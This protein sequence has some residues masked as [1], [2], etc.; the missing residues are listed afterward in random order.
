MCVT[1][2]VR[3]DFLDHEEAVRAGNFVVPIILRVPSGPPRES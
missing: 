1:D 3:S 2:E